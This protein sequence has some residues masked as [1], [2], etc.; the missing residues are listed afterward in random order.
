[1]AVIL[2]QPYFKK[3][4]VSAARSVSFEMGLQCRPRKITV[5]LGNRTGVSGSPKRI[6]VVSTCSAGLDRSVFGLLLLLEAW[7]CW[8]DWW[9]WI[10]AVYRPRLYCRTEQV[11][12]S[13]LGFLTTDGRFLNVKQFSHKT[14]MQHFPPSHAYTAEKMYQRQPLLLVRSPAR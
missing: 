2:C 8:D 6:W 3:T 14:R 7:P 11:W 9:V 12:V 13:W 5:G 10:R 4:I 1:M